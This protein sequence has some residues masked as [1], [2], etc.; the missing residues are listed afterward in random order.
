MTR[1]GAELL[2]EAAESEETAAE[3]FGSTLA[4]A[5][6][7]DWDTEQMLEDDEGEPSVSLSADSPK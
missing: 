4:L 1:R 3:S 2:K 7:I 6:S 5:M